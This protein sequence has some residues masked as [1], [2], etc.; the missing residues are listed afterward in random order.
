MVNTD[1]LSLLALV[2]VP[3]SALTLPCRLVVV[4]SALL[5]VGNTHLLLLLLSFYSWKRHH[6]YAVSMPG[7]KGDEGALLRLIPVISCDPQNTCY[8]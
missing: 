4:A 3:L 6:S 8:Y 2:P 1:L 7:I 5:G